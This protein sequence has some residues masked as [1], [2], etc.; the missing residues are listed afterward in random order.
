MNAKKAVN[1]LHGLIFLSISKEDVK[2]STH[3]RSAITKQ[4][5]R[6]CVVPNQYKKVLDILQ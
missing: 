5:R 3:F 1:E 4:L 2:K 6:K